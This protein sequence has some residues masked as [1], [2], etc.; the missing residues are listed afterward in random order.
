MRCAEIDYPIFG[1]EMHVVAV[2]LDPGATVIAEAGAMQWMDRAIAYE[3]KIGDGSAWTE[4]STARKPEGKSGAGAIL[5]A[6]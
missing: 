3:S 5:P 4:R 6:R 1:N 2:A